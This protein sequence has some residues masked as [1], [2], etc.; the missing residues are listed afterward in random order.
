MHL[1]PYLLLFILAWGWVD[2]VCISS[3]LPEGS[4]AVIDCRIKSS[5]SSASSVSVRAT[6]DA[7][8]LLVKA[9][10]PCAPK[11]HRCEGGN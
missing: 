1:H 3:I 4:A 9:G 8:Y 2:D 5:A 10:T 11:R 6:A 7:P